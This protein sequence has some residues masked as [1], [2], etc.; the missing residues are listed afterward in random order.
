MI[1]DY[2]KREEKRREERRKKKR[3][4]QS[5]KPEGLTLTNPDIGIVIT[6]SGQEHF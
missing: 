2:L 1:F 5:S 3:K 4:G 6:D